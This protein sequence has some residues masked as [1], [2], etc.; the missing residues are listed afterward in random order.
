MNVNF[1]IQSAHKID[2]A[3]FPGR[4]LFEK[5]TAAARVRFL[6]ESSSV[7]H[8]SPFFFS[9]YAAIICITTLATEKYD[10]S[11]CH[12]CFHYRFR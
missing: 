12:Y 9:V 3:M 11:S 7:Y 2:I 8:T 4:I 1:R 6:R 5:V 10:R